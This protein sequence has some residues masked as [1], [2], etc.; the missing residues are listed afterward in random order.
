MCSISGFYHPKINLLN[1][2]NHYQKILNSMCHVLHHR[3]PDEHDTVLSKHCGLAHTRL[4]IIDPHGGSQPMTRSINEHQ[5]TIIYNGEL[6]NSHELTAKLACAGIYPETSC[7][8]ELVLLS[9]LQNGPDFVKQLDG[10][11]AFAIYDEFHSQLLLCRDPFGV[12]PLFYTI[13]DGM[14][15]FSSELKGIHCYPS[16]QP[17]LKKDGLNEL[18]G[19][20]PARIPGSGV[21]DGVYELLPGS[22]V[23]FSPYGKKEEIY[24][25]I[26]AH[27]HE[28]SYEETIEKTT[29]L[30]TDAIKRQMI[31]DVPICTFLS[32][33]ID[34]SLVSSVCATQLKKEGRSLQTFSF[35]FNQNDKYF[36]SN[37]FQPTRDQPY[38]EQMVSYLHSEHTYLECDSETQ[39]ELLTQ[40]VL[41]HDL[42]AMADIDSS[43]LYFCSQVAKTHKVV[44]TGECA[45]EIFG[46]YPWFHQEQFL[47]SHTFPWTPSLKPRTDLI[48]PDLLSYLHVEEYVANAYEKAISEVDILPGEDEIETSRRRI[49]YLNIRYFMQTL[50][51][52]MDRTSMYSG[53]EAR[54]PFADKKLVD[55]IFNVPWHMK[56]KDGIVKNLLRQSAISLL[57]EE[58]LFRR[59]SPYPKTYHPYHRLCDCSLTS[60]NCIQISNFIPFHILYKIGLTL[61]NNRR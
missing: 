7:D 35:D 57:P 61:F 40:S 32:G 1:S 5:F 20:G 51:N 60:S 18:L 12:K 21:L 42:P 38:V 45:D 13:V 4:S 48:H 10:I 37:S 34:S 16:F 29:F 14:L 11:F 54:V 53:L 25:R 58:I 47:R 27:P 17:I 2:K 33:G 28:D 19:I 36:K 31:S 26:C 9:Y 55:Y 52:R 39:F 49:G 3:G 56:T 46:G 50:L 24:Y 23:T 30:V 59:K 8:T 44:L 43:L 41:A 15:V 22:I 6:Y